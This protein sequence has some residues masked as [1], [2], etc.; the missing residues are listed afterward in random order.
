MSDLTGQ[1][2]L[3]DICLG[4]CG[5]EGGYDGQTYLERITQLGRGDV[6]TSLVDYGSQLEKEFSDG[7]TKAEADDTSES[8][9]STGPEQPSVR[10][11]RG[12]VGGS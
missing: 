4:G 9:R 11:G 8:R 7:V 10:S 2:M 12:I 5:I 1:S 6:V 3:N